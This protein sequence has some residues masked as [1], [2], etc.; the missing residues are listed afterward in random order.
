[1]DFMIYKYTIKYA[2]GNKLSGYA[3]DNYNSKSKGEITDSIRKHFFGDFSVE[4][5][6]YGKKFPPIN[7]DYLLTV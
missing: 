3:I 2:N 5:R 4:V 7:T 1:M 6:K